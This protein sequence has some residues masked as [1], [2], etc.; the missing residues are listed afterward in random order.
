M[1]ENGATHQ[2]L[3][4]G[5]SAECPGSRTRSYLTIAHDAEAA[6]SPSQNRCDHVTR[7][8]GHEAIQRL[9]LQAASSTGPGTVL[10]DDVPMAV[11]PNGKPA[12]TAPPALARAVAEIEAHVGS[13]GWDQPPRLYALAPTH[14]VVA[15][16]PALADQLGIDADNPPT[17]SL[18]PIEQDIAD[19]PL[20]ELLAT[21]SWPDTVDGCALA[22]ERIVLPPGVEDDMPDDAEVAA[23][24]AQRH[25]SRSDVRI[26]VGVLRDGGKAAVM[27]VKGHD[28]ATDLIRNAEVSPDLVDALAA[29][30]S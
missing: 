5:G 19:R 2:C 15:R 10:C 13:D 17:E 26:V 6:R 11:S 9:V 8:A 28:E 24:W 4:P 20:E 21:I 25:P 27:H 23:T 12:D 1:P 3:R 22:V 14:D 30:F 18:T 7:P 16:Q 29:T